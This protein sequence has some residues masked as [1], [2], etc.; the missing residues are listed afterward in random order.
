MSDRPADPPDWV[1]WTP[2]PGVLDSTTGRTGV[3]VG[4]A[5][6]V[7]LE[8]ATNM[9]E[10]LEELFPGVTFAVVDQ[11]VAVTAFSFDEAAP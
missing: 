4:L 5:A 7:T 8:H 3:I 11:C 10:R 9:R 6:A 2:L 1:S